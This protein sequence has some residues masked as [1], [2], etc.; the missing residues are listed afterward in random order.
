MHD[1]FSRQKG[2]SKGVDETHQ[3]LVVTLTWLPPFKN[4]KLKS[5]YDSLYESV[6]TENKQI[7]IL[8]KRKNGEK[9]RIKFGNFVHSGS[10]EQ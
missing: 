2:K 9:I 5:R 3:Y 10:L 8:S 4:I 6:K 7:M 1:Y